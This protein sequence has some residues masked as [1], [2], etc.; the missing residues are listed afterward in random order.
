M[1]GGRLV[2]GSYDRGSHMHKA[3]ERV[4]KKKTRYY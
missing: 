1:R 4:E 3:P 2:V